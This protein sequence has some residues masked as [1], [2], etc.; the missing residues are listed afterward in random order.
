MLKSVVVE[1]VF[2]NFKDSYLLKVR[3]LLF[4]FLL[5]YEWYYMI[6]NGF[7]PLGCLLNFSLCSEI[8]TVTFKKEKAVDSC[9]FITLHDLL[10]HRALWGSD[11]SG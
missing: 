10:T 7:S 3:D 1:Q 6:I 9:P 2:I 5:D 11:I 8:W 4:F